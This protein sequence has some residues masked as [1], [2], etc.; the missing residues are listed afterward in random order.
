[1]IPDRITSGPKSAKEL[2]HETGSYE[3]HL[4]RKRTTSRE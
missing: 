1:L 4:W 2:A 3:P